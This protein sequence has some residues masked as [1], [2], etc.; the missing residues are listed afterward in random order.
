MAN[1]WLRLRMDSKFKRQVI[2]SVILIF[3]VM[4]FVVGFLN[5]KQIRDKFFSLKANQST[6]SEMENDE[7]AGTNETTQEND[8]VVEKFSL[9]PK[10]DPYAFHKDADFFETEADY[11]Q[12]SEH[13]LS[14]MISSVEK[15]LRIMVV[16]ET[17][18]PVMGEGFY[19][20][21]RGKNSSQ[22]EVEFYKD[23][24]Q[25]GAIYI[26][27]LK[28]GDYYVMLKAQK[29][30]Q[31]DDEEQLVKV[32]EKVTYQPIE[33]ISFMVKSEDDI[34]PSVEDTRENAASKEI[35]E[36]EIKELF[37]KERLTDDKAILGIDVSKWNRDIDWNKVKSAGIDFAII[38]C[39]YR[40]SSTGALVEDPYFLKNIT[41]AKAA[42]VNVGVY[43]FTQAI[44]EV[45]AVE[46]ASMVLMLCKS[47]ELDYPIYIDTEGA[48]GSGRADQLGKEMRTKVC[49]A[50]CKTIQ[51]G[52]ETSGIYASKSWFDNNLIMSE[53]SDYEV[54]LAQ[55][56]K[57]PTY[58]GTYGM[59][60]Y[61]S[62]GNVDGIATR[63]DL[64]LSYHDYSKGWKT[65]GQD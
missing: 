62:S 48:G 24:D 14:L 37:T 55:Y 34:D 56:A 25:D 50:F 58:E 35:F 63:T 21:L 28:S 49:D 2:L 13:K 31:V 33:D 41:N 19:V 65:N 23:L 40:G 12:T 52:G 16:D 42:G 45:E 17:Q 4:L 39:G 18:E 10:R 1:I 59:W 54:W 51:N 26:G 57:E 64:N 46:E 7:A 27:D 38:R 32:K 29:G 11:E 15:D 3:I 5:A 36:G 20:S 9:N 44:N 43:F 61:T 6:N 30:Y 47:K 22:K 8:D 60:Q 53:L